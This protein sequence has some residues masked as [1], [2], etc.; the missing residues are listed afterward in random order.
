M[1]RLSMGAVC[2]AVLV[3]VAAPRAQQPP[4]PVTVDV[5]VLDNSGKPV[6]GLKAGDFEVRDDG[7]SVPI[8][9]FEAVTRD[10]MTPA[11]GR[12]VVLLLDDTGVPAGGTTVVQTLAR[13]FLSPTMEGDAVA[14]V[15][16]HGRGD[17]L[18]GDA[19]TVLGRIDA[20][21]GGVSPFTA[22]NTPI[23]M[24]TLVADLADQM[25]AL[26]PGRKALVCVGAL[27][28][29]N[30]QEPVETASTALWTSWIRAIRATTAANVSVYAMVPAPVSLTAGG[31]ADATGGEVVSLVSDVNPTVERVWASVS[32]Y[33]LL[34]YQPTT[35]SDKE[36]PRIDVRVD[37]RGRRVVA[38]RQRAR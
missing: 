11:T 16:L 6:T 20:Y 1:K 17:G 27:P 28:V 36:L 14:A 9:G 8:Q 32:S 7:R 5:V 18:E 31:L 23:E 2:L 12:R 35:T 30:V 29:C 22:A 34:T 25:A 19:P 4:A 33:Y 21:Q 38:R 37:G 13:V 24:L 3:F 15:R 10:G 26:G